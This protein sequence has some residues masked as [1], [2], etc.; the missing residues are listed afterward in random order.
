MGYERPISMPANTSK[1]YSILA[2]WSELTG[3]EH[4]GHNI[5]ADAWLIKD[6]KLMPYE[7]GCSPESVKDPVDPSRYAALVEEGMN[8]AAKHGLE[9]TVPLDRFPGAGL[10]GY[11][12][13]T[14]GDV[15]INFLPDKACRDSF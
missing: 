13:I 8:T 1:L 9:N 10:L 2:P 3:D 7:F 11:T 4:F 5:V 14:Q 12:E 6:G 15:L